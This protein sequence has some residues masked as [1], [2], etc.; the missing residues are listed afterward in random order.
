MAQADRTDDDGVS[1]DHQLLLELQKQVAEIKQLTHH[2]EQAQSFSFSVLCAF[3][4][5]ERRARIL[6]LCQ[7]LDF[8]LCEHPSGKWDLEFDVEGKP[9]K[10]RKSQIYE[11]LVPLLPLLE[12]TKEWFFQWLVAHTNIAATAKTVKNM[13]VM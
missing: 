6:D 11:R 1:Q 5:P 10:F 3:V 8:Y 9:A 4:H 2:N 7:S 13:M 12:V